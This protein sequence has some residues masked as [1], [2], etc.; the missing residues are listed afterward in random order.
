MK[1]RRKKLSPN[2]IPPQKTKTPMSETFKVLI[3]SI[4]SEG[5]GGERREARR[6]KEETK[7][8]VSRPVYSSAASR[9]THWPIECKI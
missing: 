4:A 6:R 9:N 2:R 7:L 8:D 5:V 3:L 1:A